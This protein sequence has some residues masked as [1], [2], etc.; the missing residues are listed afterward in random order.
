MSK[1]GYP[2]RED[3]RDEFSVLSGCSGGGKSS[4]LAE[5]DRR[6]YATVPE[7]GREIVK[8]QLSVGGDGLPWENALKFTLMMVSRYMDDFDRMRS[9][10]SPTERPRWPALIGP[11]MRS[12]VLQPEGGTRQGFPLR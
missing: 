2:G 8:Q 5:L 1:D 3:R 11:I 6:G 12:A 9:H 10:H 4:L 7:P